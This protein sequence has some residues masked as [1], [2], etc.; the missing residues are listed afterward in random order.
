MSEDG[1]PRSFIVAGPVLSSQI[2]RESLRQ[3]VETFH[4]PVGWRSG[5]VKQFLSLPAVSPTL[6]IQYALMLH[7]CSTG[8]KL[9]RSDIEFQQNEA[10]NSVLQQK[11]ASNTDRFLTYYTEQQLLNNVREGNPD[12]RLS[13]ENASRLSSGI[14]AQSPDGVG[15]FLI[16]CT[17]F[18]S[19]CVRAAIEGGLSPDAAYTLGDSY[20][21]KMIKCKTVTDLRNLNHTMY[22]DFIQTVRRIRQN[23]SYSKPIQSCIDYIELNLTE[24]LSLSRL[25]RRTGYAGY[26]LT[27]KFREE[28]GQTLK[29]Y[30]KKARIK[31]AALLLETTDLSVS[32]IAE[33]L[34]FC[35]SSYFSA[36]F[37]KETGLTPNDYRHARQK[38]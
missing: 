7:Y 10:D 15:T 22:D 8:E 28:T 29:D 30:I 33:Q 25:A 34:R 5:F 6:F 19:L 36:N 3:A 4:V 1:E 17:S 26:Y 32:L 24:D 11:N 37:Q 38:M 35:S 23:P 27:R 18:V 2:S 16:S 21:Q 31:H 14:R 12:Y 9:T 20:I 13:L